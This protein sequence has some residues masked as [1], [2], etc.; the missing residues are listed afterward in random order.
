M[1]VLY[2]IREG[3]RD[4]EPL[5]VDEDSDFTGGTGSG[6]TVEA[7]EI[8]IYIIYGITC[9]SGEIEDDEEANNAEAMPAQTGKG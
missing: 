5:D 7:L 6:G 9:L 2:I 1:H 3:R 4:Q 8:S